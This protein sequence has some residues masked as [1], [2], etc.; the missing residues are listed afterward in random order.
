MSPQQGLDSICSNPPSLLNFPLPQLVHIWR[1]RR[2]RDLLSVRSRPSIIIR[3][4]NLDALSPFHIASPKY[5]PRFESVGLIFC[6]L[7]LPPRILLDIL[8]KIHLH[9]QEIEGSFFFELVVMVG[10]PLLVRDESSDSKDDEVGPCHDTF[11]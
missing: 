7:S 11:S 1:N 4:K 2:L 10:S 5:P 8:H 3:T 6:G 9:G